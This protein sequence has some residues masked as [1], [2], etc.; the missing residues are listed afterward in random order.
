[1]AAFNNIAELP[2]EAVTRLKTIPEIK[3]ILQLMN[4][5][6]TKHGHRLDRI[7]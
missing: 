3:S 5:A 2:N 4:E 6:I 1:M 7:Q